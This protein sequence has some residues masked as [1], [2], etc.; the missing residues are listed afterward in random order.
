MALTRMSIKEYVEYRLTAGNKISTVAVA[1]AIRM[2]HRTP[3]IKRTEMIG[4]TYLLWV[5]ITELDSYLV[6]I[7]KPVK[8]RA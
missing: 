6:S 1:K 2:H 4:R 3:G 8:L 7:K 5:D